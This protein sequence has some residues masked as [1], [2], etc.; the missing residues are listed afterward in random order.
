MSDRDRDDTLLLDDEEDLDSQAHKFLLFNIAGEVFGINIQQV[1][2]IIELQNITLVPDMPDYVKGVIN[3]RGKVIPVID[4]RLRFGMQAREYDDRTCIINVNINNNS[5]GFIVD[6]V[7]EVHDIPDKDIEP[8]P[9]FKANIGHRKYISG[10]GKVGSEVKI[11][12]DVDKILFE[13]EI[14][15]ITEKI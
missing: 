3:L 1:T 8:P 10:L 7:A 4:L 11:L 5:I 13:E 9:E 2:E 12:L 6:T 15:V 14:A